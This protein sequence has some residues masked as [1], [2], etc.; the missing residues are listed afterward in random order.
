MLAQ[1][2]KTYITTH[3]SNLKMVHRYQN[4]SFLWPNQNDTKF[5]LLVLIC[6]INYQF[7][8]PQ[9]VLAIGTHAKIADGH[10][11]PLNLQKKFKRKK[12]KFCPKH[13]VSIA[14]VLPYQHPRGCYNSMNKWH[15][16]NSHVCKKLNKKV[17]DLIQIWFLKNSN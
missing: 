1:C 17:T 6:Y 16:Q 13:E 9:S 11:L 10:V 14:T 15:L 7:E 8:S 4:I 5:I 12:K 2:R 3:I